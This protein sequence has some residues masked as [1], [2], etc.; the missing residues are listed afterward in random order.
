MLDRELSASRRRPQPR[1]SGIGRDQDAGGIVAPLRVSLL[2]G[3]RAERVDLARPA[4]EWKRRSAKSLTKLLAVHHA[5]SLHRE[6]ILDILWPGLDLDPALNSFGKAL[7]EARR[8][9]EPELLPRRSS[10]YLQLCDSMVSLNTE[11]VVIDADCFQRLADDALRRRE[12]GAY[13]AALEVYGG[14]LLPEDRYEDWCAERRGFLSEL[15]IRLLL[16]LAEALQASGLYMES[17]DRLREVLEEDATREEVHRRLMRMYS[18]IGSRDR[19]LRQ[20]HLCRDILGRELDLA[21]Q[22]ETVSLYQDILADRIPGATP[23]RHSERVSSGPLRPSQQVAAKQFIGRE[24]VLRH[25]R[26]QLTPTQA[27][28]AG[29]VIITG[30][31][32]VGKTRLLEEFAAEARR[33]G[34]VVLWGGSGAHANHLARGPFAVALEDYVASRSEAERKDIA[35]RHPALARCLPSLPIDGAGPFAFGPNYDLPAAM[36]RLLTDLGQRQPVLLVLGDLQEADSFTRDLLR[37]IAHLAL[38]RQWLII[39]ALREEEIDARTE[40]QRTIEAMVRERLCS[41]LELQCLP[42]AECDELVRA[43]LSGERVDDEL[44]EAIYTGACGNPLFVE[45]L[46]HELREARGVGGGSR[47]SSA[48]LTAQITARVP[49]GVRSLVAMRLAEM[50]ETAGRVLALA[51]AARAT[52]ISLTELRAGAAALDPPVSDAALFAALDHALRMGVLEEHEH[53]YTFR[54]PLVRSALCEGLSRHRRAELDAALG[55]A[56]GDGSRRLRVAAA[57]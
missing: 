13:E 9:L 34:V 26:E 8:A 35:R 51:A 27:G 17:A 37:Y 6:Q 11:R 48:V 3:F 36:V 47:R 45:E 46:V 52:E 21:P 16:G 44:L 2:G 24:E 39:G 10:R 22:Q 57:R 40:L 32:G 7:H 50:E 4:C 31:A 53:G 56:R 14:E 30:E 41:K 20:F 5:H 18:K 54:H 1:E 29:L 12:I 15:H 43:L 38:T 19:A 25:L 49:P 28:R 23:E 33:A 55:R 42:R